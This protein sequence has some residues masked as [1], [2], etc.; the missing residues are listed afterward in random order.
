MTPRP[1]SVSWGKGM[2]IDVFCDL[3]L[4][5]ASAILRVEGHCYSLILKMGTA[6]FSEMLVVIY[7][8]TL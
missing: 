4:K 7:Q 2:E 1:L 6:G 3:M 5:L 8:A